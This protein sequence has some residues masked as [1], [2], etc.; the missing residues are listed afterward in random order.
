VAVLSGCARLILRAQGLAGEETVVLGAGAACVVP[1]DRWHRLE[2]DGPTELQS[3][4]P[5]RGSR[6][7]PAT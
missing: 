7:E 2:V 1:R 3:I 4:T 5:R 6:V